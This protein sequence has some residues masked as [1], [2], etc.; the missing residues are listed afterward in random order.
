MNFLTILESKR[1]GVELSERQIRWF[2]DA[3]VR[4]GLP[5]YQVSAFLMAIYFRGLSSAETRVLTQSM[6]ESGDQLDF[7]EDPR[8]LVDKHSTGGVGDKVSLVLA[9]LLA[10]LGMR[11]PMMAGRGL[12]ITG[13]T[14]DKL[15]SIPGFQTRRTREQ[16]VAQVQEIGC[17][18]CGQTEQMVPADR[19][20]YAMRD[21]TGTVPSIPLITASILSKKLSESLEALVLDVTCGRAAFMREPAAARVLAHDMVRLASQ[22][23]VKTRALITSMDRPLGRSAGNW[24]EILEVEECLKGRGPEDLRE[25]V[26]EFGVE[27]LWLSGLDRD[28]ASALS[29]LR[30]LLKQGAAHQCWLKM[31]AAQG[32]DVE[33]YSRRVSEGSTAKVLREFPS[34]RGGVLRDCDARVIGE[35]VRDLG[36]GRFSKSDQPLLEV[37]VDRLIQVGEPVREGQPLVRLHAADEG[38]LDRVWP[39]LSRAFTLGDESPP[40]Q[41]LIVDRVG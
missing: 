23:G 34:P 40:T 8:P 36:G 18:I 29:C 25:L 39:A 19:I 14:L 41:P 38:S 11:I 9:P 35:V 12:G 13:G 22:C 33:L 37:G 32:A 31:L 1:D 2:V 17:C 28:R 15:E 10:C 7:P 27:L 16:I 21:V 3:L 5:E 24:L 30:D 6:R 4:G 20:L 26:L